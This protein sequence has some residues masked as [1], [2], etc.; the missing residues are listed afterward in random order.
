MEHPGSAKSYIKQDV[1]SLCTRLTIFLSYSVAPE[2]KGEKTATST[3]K[4]HIKLH[5]RV[6]SLS[7]SAAADSP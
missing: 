5:R 7:D 6:L 3:A 4:P 2:K 1:F